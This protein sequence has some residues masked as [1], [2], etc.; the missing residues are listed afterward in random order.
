MPLRNGR[1][2]VDVAL[3]YFRSR[4]IAARSIDERRTV[5]KCRSFLAH[6]QRRTRRRAITEPRCLAE[7]FGDSKKRW[8]WEP[9]ANTT[10]LPEVKLRRRADPSRTNPSC[11]GCKC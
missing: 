4:D 2:E 8:T 3:L 9:K 10:V 5:E 1:A 6:K 7:L 11:F